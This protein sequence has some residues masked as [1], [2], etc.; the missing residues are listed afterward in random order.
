MHPQQNWYL[1]DIATFPIHHKMVVPIPMPV[2]NAI[3][4]DTSYK[5]PL[6]MLQV[7][8]VVYA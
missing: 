3:L 5:G 8:F 6:N 2:L 7:L 4:A 1:Y